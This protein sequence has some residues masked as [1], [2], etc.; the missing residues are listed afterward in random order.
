MAVALGN[1]KG[2]EVGE[3]RKV[4]KEKKGKKIYVYIFKLKY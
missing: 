2:K 3:G 4:K 1:D